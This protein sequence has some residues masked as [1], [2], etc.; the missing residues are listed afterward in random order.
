MQLVGLAYLCGSLP[1]YSEHRQAVTLA[2]YRRSSFW[3][4]QASLTMK[5]FVCVALW[6]PRCVLQMQWLLDIR[7]QLPG[8]TR[9]TGHSDSE[10]DFFGWAGNFAFTG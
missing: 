10:V 2:L 5:V 3:P 8:L 1:S 9:V 4:S 7:G 6:E